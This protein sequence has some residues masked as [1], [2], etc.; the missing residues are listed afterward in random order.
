MPME[1][2]DPRPLPSP[3][4][5][6]RADRALKACLGALSDTLSRHETALLG[7][8]SGETLHDYRVAVRRIRSLLGQFDAVFTERRVRRFQEEFARL[9]RL[10]SP[11]RD[12]EVCVAGFA[13]G[14]SVLEPARRILEARLEAARAQL[15]RHIGTARH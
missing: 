4:L 3:G 11:A 15:R 8:E 14:E 10:T 1:R 13:G 2:A 5:G 7:G 12:L 6:E 9:A